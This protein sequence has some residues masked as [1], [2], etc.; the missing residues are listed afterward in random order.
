MEL[1]IEAVKYLE[2]VLQKRELHESHFLVL[3]KLLRGKV[4]HRLTVYAG[5]EQSR[6]IRCLF[7]PFVPDYLRGMVVIPFHALYGLMK[8]C[9]M[10]RKHIAKQ[11]KRVKHGSK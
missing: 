3:G 9:N 11:F 4:S 1:D 7:F 8:V 10:P 5:T 6:T 2:I